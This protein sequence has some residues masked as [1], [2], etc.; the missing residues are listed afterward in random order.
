MPASIRPA[1]TKTSGSEDTALRDAKRRLGRLISQ[2]AVVRAL[3][4]NVEAL[5]RPAASG[6]LDGQ[7]VEEMARLGCLVLETAASL[8][9]LPE[10]TCRDSGV[11]ERHSFGLT[12]EGSA[13]S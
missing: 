2:V 6:G 12:N 9:A 3:A 5:A 13:S 4:D 11:F 8:A 1:A 10:A 7:L